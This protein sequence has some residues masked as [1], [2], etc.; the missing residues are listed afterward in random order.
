[1]TTMLS[2]HVTTYLQGLGTGAGLIIA[3]GAQNAYVL[4]Q[5]LKRQQTFL[6][7][8]TCALCDAVLIGLGA[9]GFASFVRAFPALVPVA[10]WGGA[11]FL[12]L[13]GGLAF[14]NALSP[15]V[16]RAAGDTGK[17]ER[18]GRLVLTAVGFSLL[19]PH[20]WLDTVVLL[21]GI[22]SS[23][24]GTERLGFALGAI[25]ASFLWFF[26]LGY[27]AAKLAPVF[28]RPVAWRVLDVAIGVVM[29]TI[30]ISLVLHRPGG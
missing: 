30:A 9:G 6:V 27:G 14:R 12:V 25:S 13:Y 23:F 26:G 15:G 10:S 18:A 29:W 19:N 8:L 21:G 2:P 3:I 1:M 24:S 11:A 22:S 4:R 28:S 5:G 7:A 17:P 20:A 16:L